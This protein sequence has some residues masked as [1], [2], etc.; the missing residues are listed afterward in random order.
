MP[1][2][3]SPIDES[4]FTDTAFDAEAMLH[5]TYHGQNQTTYA[6]PQTPYAQPAN[7]GYNQGMNTQETNGQQQAPQ[8][9][10]SEATETRQTRSSGNSAL[11]KAINLIRDSRTVMFLGLV[12]VVVAGYSLIVTISYFANIG[13]DQS[14]MLN[15]DFDPSM[16]K[17]AGGPVGAWM[18]HTLLYN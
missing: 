9:T 2:Q 4:S 11:R 3:Y 15:S 10:V 14:A 8:Q 12:L 6:N 5:D 7:P 16:I 17:N 13:T 18:A 1:T